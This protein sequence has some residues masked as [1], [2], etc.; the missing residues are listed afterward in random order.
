MFSVFHDETWMSAKSSIH[1]LSFSEISAVALL[2][3]LAGKGR[4][5][6]LPAHDAEDLIVLRQRVHLMTETAVP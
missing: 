1:S 4:L 5:T 6:K 2:D 3:N